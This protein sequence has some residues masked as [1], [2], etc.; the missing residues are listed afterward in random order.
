MDLNGPWTAYKYKIQ[1]GIMVL[2]Q[3][4]FVGKDYLFK[5]TEFGMLSPRCH[6][7][8]QNKS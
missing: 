2:F 1:Y 6:V 7:L 4:F 3:T 8:D 5:A